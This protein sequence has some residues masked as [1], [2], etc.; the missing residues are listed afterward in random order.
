LSRFH[1]VLW[2]W[3]GWRAIYDRRDINAVATMLRERGNLPEGTRLHLLTDQQGDWYQTRTK[4]LGVEE[5]KLWGDVVP[6]VASGRPNCFRRL[7]LFDADVQRVLGIEVDDIVMS[8]DADSAVLGPIAPLLDKFHA[9]SHNFAGMEGVASRIHGS[10]FAFRAY[11]HQHLWSTFHPI[12]SPRVLQT[13]WKGGPRPIGSDQAWMTRNVTGEYLWRRV[14]DGC[15]SWNRHG[16]IYSPRYTSNAVYWSFAGNC[17]PGGELVRQIRPDLH[18]V[19][20]DA[21]NRELPT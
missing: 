17:K 2:L 15:Y 11:S 16:A 4:L 10:L 19:W 13:P 18:E 20:M 21:Y 5:H 14:E 12:L 8:M 3:K 7:K 9:R 6:Y 1:I